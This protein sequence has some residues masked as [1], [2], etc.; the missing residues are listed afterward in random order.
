LTYFV[1]LSLA[2]AYY[3]EVWIGPVVIL[4]LLTLA[5]AF[6]KI[7]DIPFLKYIL[8]VIEYSRNVQKRKWMPLGSKIKGL[9]APRPAKEKKS[10]KEAAAEK[11]I[12]SLS[13]VSKLLDRNTFDHV[14]N[15]MDDSIDGVSDKYLL[16]E[17]FLGK[18]EEDLDAHSERLKDFGKEKETQVHTLEDDGVVHANDLKKG[19]IEVRFPRKENNYE[20]S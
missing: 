11:T 12:N 6:L 18:K 1:Y 4:G 3:I 10:K 5:L 19:N 17:T 9:T 16:H 2:K 15:K 14:K 20:T 13:N 8:L 7:H